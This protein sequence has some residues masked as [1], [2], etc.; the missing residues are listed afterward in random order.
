MQVSLEIQ[1][2]PRAGEIIVVPDG[3]TI[4]VGRTASASFALPQDTFLSRVHFAVAGGPECRLIDRQSA[5]G[6]SLNGSRIT[7][8]AAVHE[9]DV[10]AAGQTKFLVHIAAGVT[11]ASKSPPLEA[12]PSS[13]AAPVVEA[14]E[15]PGALAIGSWFFGTVP[16][17]WQ[18]VEGFGLRRHER[19]SFPSEAMV[20]EM[21]LAPDQSFDQFVDEQ[22]KLLQFLVAQPQIQSAEPSALRGAEEARAF[23]VRYKTE[24]GQ[25]FLQRQTY[26]RRA[27]IAGTLAVTTLE[28]EAPAVQPVI[29]QILRGLGFGK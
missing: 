10:I 17:G 14:I 21:A 9:G 19:N 13:A 22:L 15:S 26:V 20:S 11:A 5:N 28:G 24:D 4:T 2:G 7:E 29:D 12:L 3:Q 23:S 18:V 16:D 25:R 8:S 6:T 1:S 27:R